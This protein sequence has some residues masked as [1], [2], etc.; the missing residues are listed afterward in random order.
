MEARSRRQLLARGNVDALNL[1][2]LPMLKREIIL[3]DRMEARDRRRAERKLLNQVPG[4]NALFTMPYRPL[5]SKTSK[6]CGSGLRP[7]VKIG[8]RLRCLTPS[9]VRKCSER[10]C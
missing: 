4:G 2:S 6:A 9:L 1:D 5:T 8:M 10:V 7:R 3:A